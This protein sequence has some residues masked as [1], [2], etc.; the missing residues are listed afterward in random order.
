M[1]EYEFPVILGR[2]FAGIVE[3]AG[4]GVTRYEVGDEVLGFVLHANPAARRRRRGP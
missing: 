3:E 4:S 2:D 1:A